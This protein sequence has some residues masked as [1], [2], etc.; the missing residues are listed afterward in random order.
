MELRSFKDLQA[1][2]PRLSTIYLGGGTPSLL[3]SRNIKKL[4]L[5]INKVYGQ[6]MTLEDWEQMEVTME[7]NPDDISDEFCNVL[8]Q[9]PVNRISM[10]VQTFSD[11]RL[12]FLHRRHTVKQVEEAVKRIRDC[13]IKNISIDL[14]FGF[15]NEKINEWE[16]D[17][18]HALSL[19][20]EHI[21][22]YSLMYDEGTRLDEMRKQH[23]L[24]EL[25]EEVSLQMYEMLM[26]KLTLAGYEHYEI[27][28]FALPGYRS[29]HNSS[30]WQN[31][32]Y[33]GI[34]AAAHS[35]DL[36][37]RQW[38]IADIR[39]YMDSI[40]KGIIP[41]EYEVI[42]EDTHYND[43]ITT[44][45]RTKEGICLNVL[46]DKYKSYL[47]R[48]AQRHIENQLLAIDDGRLHLTR[49]GI[50]VSDDIMSDLIFV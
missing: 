43:L 32:P 16:E 20:V 1:S 12:R 8:R 6:E 9:L 39:E 17:I 47:I 11:D 15:P 44:A 14:M 48:N 24:K 35:Y 4:F 2:E 26:D 22:A 40:E 29:R 33:I 23:L 34:G 3:S 27:S 50:F 30:Y 46:P 19:N 5:Y 49:K 18:R 10:G 42:D 28:N 36:H 7:C 37:K 38:N 21:S 31:T 13:G 41:C 45:L 25:D